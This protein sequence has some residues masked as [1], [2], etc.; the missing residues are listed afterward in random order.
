MLD[1]LLP[2]IV[3]RQLQLLMTYLWLSV[4]MSPYTAFLKDERLVLNR[5]PH[6]FHF[7]KTY[8]P[9]VYQ[10]IEDMS[11][12]TTLPRRSESTLSGGW[13]RPLSTGPGLGSAWP[14]PTLTLNCKMFY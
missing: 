5:L 8:V 9:S 10:Q 12:G 4:R 11:K 2:E 1:K 7:I 14:G 13:A 6:S 3:V